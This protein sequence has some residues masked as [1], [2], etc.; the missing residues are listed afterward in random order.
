MDSGSR[1]CNCWA[2]LLINIFVQSIIIQGRQQRAQDIFYDY[3]ERV[4]LLQYRWVVHPM[5]Y[6]IVCSIDTC[7]EVVQ[8]VLHFEV[9][10]VGDDW[11]MFV[12]T[13]LITSAW[14][15]IVIAIPANF[16]EFLGVNPRLRFAVKVAPRYVILQ[17]NGHGRGM[18]P[19]NFGT[20]ASP[21]P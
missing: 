7:M 18:A 17:L 11:R 2:V 1:S 12:H 5:R 13:K 15:S 21:V 10:A 6:I 14:E 20:Q 9:M 16:W 4:L 19:K 3:T 8:R